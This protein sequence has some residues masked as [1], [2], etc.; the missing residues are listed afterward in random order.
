L[1]SG[2]GGTTRKEKDEHATAGAATGDAASAPAAEAASKSG[3]SPPCAQ[4]EESAVEIQALAQGAADSSPAAKQPLDRVSNDA[5]ALNAADHQELEARREKERIDREK[6]NAYRRDLRR[7]KAASV[8]RPSDASQMS[9]GCPADIQQTSGGQADAPS[10]AKATLEESSPPPSGDRPVVKPKR[11]RP[12]E[13]NWVGSE[14]HTENILTQLK[15][16]KAGES[17]Y[18][19]SKAFKNRQ[20]FKKFIQENVQYVD[21]SDRGNGPDRRTV[22]DAIAEHNL[23]Q[24][25][26]IEEK[27]V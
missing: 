11:G 19:G 9:D 3:A 18:R 5:G 17:L 26:I 2:G 16:K 13:W 8:G 1:P 21:G 23:E 25:A 12:P 24:Y 15:R 4:S 6:E 10:G 22:D 7:K 14:T 20:F 27:R